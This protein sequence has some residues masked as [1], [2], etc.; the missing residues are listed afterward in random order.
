L[1]RAGVR[2][3]QGIVTQ[4]HYL[5]KPIDARCSVEGYAI[6]CATVPEVLGVF[7]LG[8]PQ[9]T[10][11]YPWYGSVEDVATGRAEVTRWQVLNVARIWVSPR[12]QPGGALH[13]PELLP[14]FVD[15]KGAFRSEL[16]SEALLRLR[17]Q[18]GYDYLLRRPPCFLDEPYAIRWLFSYCDTR[19]HR[20]TIYPAAGFAHFRTNEQ[21]IATWRIPL[22]SLAG[23]QD[24]N[25]RRA[26]EVSPR[27]RTYRARRAQLALLEVA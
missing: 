15:R 20:G 7:L 24:A 19:I 3:A 6:E 27:S 25:V 12:V 26:A 14:G 10:A 17:G 18:V 1:D 13:T 2:A 22:P 16:V 21:G 4:E 23:W 11:C 8:R 5:R 9:A